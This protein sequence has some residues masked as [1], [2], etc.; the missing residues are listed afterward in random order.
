V[1]DT[2]HCISKT[3]VNK[4]FDV[5]ALEKLQIDRK[6]K[7]GKRFSRLLGSWSPSELDKFIAYKAESIGK[8]TVFVNPYKTSQRCSRCGFVHRWNRHGLRFRC[9]NCGFEL[10]ADLNAARNIGVLG[11]SEYLR[12]HVNEPIIASNEASPTREVDD[13]YKPPNLLGGS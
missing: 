3:I 8:V 2:N 12:L 9:G 13:S 6:K 1:L 11:K 10:N 5:F 4:P 7:W